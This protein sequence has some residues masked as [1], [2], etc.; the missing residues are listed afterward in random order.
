MK[1]NTLLRHPKATGA[2]LALVSILVG[3]TAL[4]AADFGAPGWLFVPLLIWLGTVGL[5][6]TVAVLLLAS[7]WGR[8]SPLYGFWIFCFV[9]AVLAT[10]SHV[11][12][13]KALARFSG[14]R[15]DN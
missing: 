7:V 14:G 4:E 13:V 15:H 2:V 5:P 3:A 12:A 6:S 9:A 11:M 1:L 8:M 10:V